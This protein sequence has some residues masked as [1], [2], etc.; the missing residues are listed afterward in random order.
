MA[1]FEEVTFAQRP[2]GCRGLGSGVRGG[3]A[4]RQR[5]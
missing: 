5:E 3:E 1:T 4:S 2:G